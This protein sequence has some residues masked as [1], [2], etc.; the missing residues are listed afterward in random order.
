MDAQGAR[1][2]PPWDVALTALLL[3]A[4]LVQTVLDGGEQVVLRA[5]LASLTVAGLLVRRTAPGLSATWIAIGL[6]V[7]SLVTESPDQLG[8]LLAVLISAFSVAAW[9]PL[10]DALM[11][12]GL[13]ALGISLTI[14]VDPS[15]ELSNIA[16]T[17][18]MFLV[19]P[20][21]LGFAFKRRTHDIAALSRRADELQREAGQAVL[22]ERSRIARELHDVVSH[23]VTVIAVQAEAGQAVIDQDPEAA[24]R[25]LASISAASRDALAELHSLLGLLGSPEAADPARGLSSV[26]TLVAGVRAA[27]LHV[28]LIEEGPAPVLPRELDLCAYRVV[29]EGLTNA[30]RH[31]RRP[32]VTVHIETSAAALN[33]GVESVGPAHQSSYGGSGRGLEGLRERVLSLGGAFHSG[34]SDG[35]RYSLRVTL[36]QAAP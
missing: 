7:E 17:L 35:N 1:W 9:A 16:P 19:I 4:A 2:P 23:A 26:G 27:G 5:A 36:P 18:L 10:R 24:K 11:G 15:D 31:M 14:A 12:L 21:A 32:D 25:S 8:V 20:A 33:I 29:Q 6:A 34:T 13:L 28:D 30:I 22:A 3:V